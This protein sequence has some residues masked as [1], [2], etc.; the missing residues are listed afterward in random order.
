[1]EDPRLHLL[2]GQLGVGLK[3]QRLVDEAQFF[4]EFLEMD[5]WKLKLDSIV[6]RGFPDFAVPD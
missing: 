5:R 1:M 3:D 4:L 6:Q 2:L